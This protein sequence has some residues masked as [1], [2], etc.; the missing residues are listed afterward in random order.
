MKSPLGLTLFPRTMIPLGYDQFP[1]GT[2]PGTSA[3]LQQFVLTLLVTHTRDGP[4]S[5]GLVAPGNPSP[6]SVMGM[7]SP[8]RY[9]IPLNVKYSPVQGGAREI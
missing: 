3:F 7:V 8:G 1:T 4:G 5:G 2:S 6:T 9:T